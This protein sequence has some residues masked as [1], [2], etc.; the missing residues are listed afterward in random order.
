MKFVIL[1][2]CITLFTTASLAIVNPNENVMGPYFDTDADLDCLEGV[3]VNTEIPIYIILT[4]P[5]FSEING[6]EMGMDYG[7]NLILIGQEF[8]N[9]E[10]LNVGSGD[11]FIVGFGN[12]TYTDDA[13]LLMTLSMLH[14]G[15]TS[16]PTLLMTLS[17]FPGPSQCRQTQP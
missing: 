14:L 6:F 15:T 7:S 10:A 11:D 1:L 2:T 16:S 13:T 12:P 4:R 3:E 9:T 5:T 8:A 17:M